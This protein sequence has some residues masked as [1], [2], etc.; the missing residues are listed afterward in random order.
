MQLRPPPRMAMAYLLLVAGYS[1]FLS[2]YLADRSASVLLETL[3]WTVL[4]SGAMA[5]PG[6]AVR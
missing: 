4:G 3:T 5:P 1:T 6:G 2:V